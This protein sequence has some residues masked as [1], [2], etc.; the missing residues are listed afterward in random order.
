M[1]TP[2]NVMTGARA[3]ESWQPS[4]LDRVRPAELEADVQDEGALQGQQ[5]G[6]TWESAPCRPGGRRYGVAREPARQLI[7][8]DR[9]AAR[10][11]AGTYGRSVESGRPIPIARL[12]AAPLADR[13][14]EE[15]AAIEALGG[16]RRRLTDPATCAG[17]RR[18][19]D[20][21]PS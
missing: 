17:I 7:A 19:A 16:R 4:A 8:A 9:A 15:Q 1:A 12:E 14:M 10:I 18:A 3:R 13:T 6:E 21:R 5:T 2:E 20:D 11:D